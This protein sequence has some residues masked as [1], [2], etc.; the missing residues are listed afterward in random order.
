MKRQAASVKRQTGEW[1]GLVTYIN[2]TGDQMKKMD[3]PLKLLGNRSQSLQLFFFSVAAIQDP[4][5]QESLVKV[6]YPSYVYST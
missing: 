2:T 5:K 1:P 6:I 3:G 4:R